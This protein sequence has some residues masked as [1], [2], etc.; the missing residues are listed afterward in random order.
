MA[1]RMA[2]P[3]TVA[4]QAGAAGAVGAAGAAAGATSGGSGGANGC[5][6]IESG[7]PGSGWLEGSGTAGPREER[8]GAEILLPGAAVARTRERER[9]GGRA[10][11]EEKSALVAH[12]KDPDSA[13]AF[14][15]SGKML[16][17]MMYRS[18]RPKLHWYSQPLSTARH[19]L[20]QDAPSTNRL[21]AETEG[22]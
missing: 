15:R 17:V 14:C 10:V 22:R 18:G 11:R 7:R 12:G 1:V 4:W 13:L 9:V 6:E 21:V 8:H 20:M 16:S 3:K 19:R 5:A 2:N